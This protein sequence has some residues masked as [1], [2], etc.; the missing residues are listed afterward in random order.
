MAK[1]VERYSFLRTIRNIENCD[2]ALIVLDASEGIVE[3]DQKIA[4]FVTAAKKGAIMILNKWDLV[5]KDTAT[6]D[7]LKKIVYDRLW[8]MKHVPVLTISALN[9][10]RATKIFPIID[11]VL[12][13]CSKRIS[14]HELNLFLRNAVSAK[15]PPLY[16]GK[17]VKIYYISQVKTSPPGFIIFTNRKEGIKPQYLKY[18]EHK[19]RD[20]FTFE[21]APV[22]FYI[23]QR[24]QKQGMHA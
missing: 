12:E 20:R 21:G 8:F 1:T 4:G 14:T 7:D 24:K 16:R 11:T 19:L 23:R 10:K 5:S 22:D 9:K 2:V 17:K 3:L 15:E 6:A 13:E 18:L